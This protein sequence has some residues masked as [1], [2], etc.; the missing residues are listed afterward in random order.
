VDVLTY[1]AIRSYY[2]YKDR[3]SYPAYETIADRMGM[4][5]SF[6]MD[7]TDR[8]IKAG[9][10]N[11]QRRFNNSNVYTFKGATIIDKIPVEVLLLDLSIYEK[12]ML[13]LLRQCCEGTPTDISIN[14]TNIAAM[15]GI[16][17]KVVNAQMHSL[18]EQGYVEEKIN[19]ITKRVIGY[20]LTSVIDWDYDTDYKLDSKEE[21]LR[22]LLIT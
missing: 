11:K 3:N 16:S 1:L 20:K 14:M 4:S 10:I 12:A 5:K 18:L 21:E 17:Y 7:S 13:V 15:L 22:V 8:L 9:F 6:V 19:R 2:N